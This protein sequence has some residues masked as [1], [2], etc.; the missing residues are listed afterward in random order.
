[1]VE[2]NQLVNDARTCSLNK[3]HKIVKIQTSVSSFP[4]SKKQRWFFSLCYD[5][6]RQFHCGILQCLSE[7]FHI[8]DQALYV[9]YTSTIHLE[10]SN[11]W[12]IGHCSSLFWAAEQTH[13]WNQFGT[14][15]D[16]TKFIASSGLQQALFKLSRLYSLTLDNEFAAL[17]SLPGLYSIVKS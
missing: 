2:A 9:L 11:F 3:C 4:A 1:M 16:P 13:L 6:L 10:Q 15:E 17:F 14:G 7:S 8:L 12:K 5:N